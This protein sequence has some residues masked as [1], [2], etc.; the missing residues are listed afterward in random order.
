[1]TIPIIKLEEQ[2]ENY[3]LKYCTD[4]L[5]ETVFKPMFPDNPK[6]VTDECTKCG[7]EVVTPK[8]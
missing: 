8:R 7:A 3:Y 2:P 5:E 6:N 4:C 1:M